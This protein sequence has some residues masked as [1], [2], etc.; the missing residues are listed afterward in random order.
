LADVC[1]LPGLIFPVW[2]ADHYFDAGWNQASIIA[3]L[4]QYVDAELNTVGEIEPAAA[5]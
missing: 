2:G 5:S 1:C 4:L 3:A